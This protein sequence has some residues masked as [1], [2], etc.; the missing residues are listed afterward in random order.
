MKLGSLTKDRLKQEWLTPRYEEFL[1]SG[2][3]ANVEAEHAKAILSRPER[4]RSI[5]WSASSAGTCLRAQIY[6]ARKAEAAKI[7]TKSL[8]IFQHGHYVHLKHQVAG[9]TAGYIKAVE[10]PV[11][12]PELNVLG[13]MDGETSEEEIAEFKSIN[14]R[15]FSRVRQFG[16]E[17]KHRAQVNAYMLASNLRRARV[18]YEDKND[19]ELREFLVEFDQEISD[20]NVHDWQE[21]NAHREMGTKPPMQ[22]ECKRGEGEIKW[23]PFAKICISDHKK[24][25]R[26]SRIR[27]T[28]SSDVV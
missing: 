17:P 15:G 25:G 13:T 18:L 3:D 19:Q 7:E 26:V 24:E 16:V 10:V 2:R 23:C 5:G 4:D 22:E 12:I 27:R 21:L 28:S 14:Y 1:R 11:A 20:R 9:L 8:K 6:K